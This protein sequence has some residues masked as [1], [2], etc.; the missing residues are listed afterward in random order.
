MVAE[1]DRPAVD[2]EEAAGSETMPS[3]SATANPAA[4]SGNRAVALPCEAKRPARWAHS[5]PRAGILVQYTSGR[6]RVTLYGRPSLCARIMG[7]GNNDVATSLST[8]HA[9]H[10]QLGT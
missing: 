2:A 6:T 9:N 7:R 8:C 10:L 5:R 3:A 1:L 4:A